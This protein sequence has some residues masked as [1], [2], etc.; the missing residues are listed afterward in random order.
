MSAYFS[1]IYE[2]RIELLTDGAV[3]NDEGV[4]LEVA[5]KVYRSSRWPLAMTSRGDL[6]L[7]EAFGQYLEIVGAAVASVDELISRLQAYLD[8]RR[9]KGSPEPFEILIAAFVADGPVNLYFSSD[10]LIE[11]IEPWVIHQVG[12]E[13]GGGP[14]F[15][16]D[17]LKAEGISVESLSSGLEENGADLM[18]LMRKR[19][20]GHPT[21]PFLPDVYGIGGHVDLTIVRPGGV[22]TKRLH[23]WPDVIGQPIDPFAVENALRAAVA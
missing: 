19:K 4:L 22:T 12:P 8:G 7:L 10:P 1:V 13:F 23:I 18:K 5:E 9:E 2:D 11:G 16:L 14:M 3:Y 15:T 20:G 17:D 6:S 21:K